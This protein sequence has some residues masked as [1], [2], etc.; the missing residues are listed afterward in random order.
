MSIK[1]N[2]IKCLKQKTLYVQ[3]VFRNMSN[4]QK[5]TMVTYVETANIVDSRWVGR[6]QRDAL[7]L[8]TMYLIV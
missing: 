2:G 8:E 5:V 7:G 1:R 6:V 4:I 3:T